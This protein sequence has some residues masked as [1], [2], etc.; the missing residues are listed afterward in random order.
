MNIDKQRFFLPELSCNQVVVVCLV[1][2]VLSLTGCTKRLEPYLLLESA[3]IVGP[4]GRIELEAAAEMWSLTMRTPA[5]SNERLLSFSPFG[6]RGARMII[7]RPI[8]PSGPSFDVVE[9][10]YQL[11]D[12]DEIVLELIEA[13]QEDFSDGWSQAILDF[14]RPENLAGIIHLEHG[15]HVTSMIE[16]I[17][18]RKGD[19]HRF[20]VKLIINDEPHVLD[21]SFKIELD[22]NW[23]SNVG[24]FG[25]LP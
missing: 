25:G 11:N 22:T 6:S 17:N 1:A 12:G 3:S 21:A 4:E 24:S 13:R 2:L 20:Y 14:T 23:Y 10:L 16:S 5:G 8:G 9:I 7:E 15:S 19:I 18:D